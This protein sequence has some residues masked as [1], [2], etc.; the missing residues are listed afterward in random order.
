MKGTCHD[1]VKDG[2]LNF[3]EREHCI[4]TRDMEIEIAQA[5]LLSGLHTQGEIL[6]NG[7][8]DQYGHLLFHYIRVCCP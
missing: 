5:R 1:E 4:H 8:Q 2:D 3:H 6:Y 7:S